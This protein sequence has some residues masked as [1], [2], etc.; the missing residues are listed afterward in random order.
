M[1]DSAKVRLV[2]CPKCENLLP[3]LADYSVYQCGGCGAVLRAKKKNCEVDAALSDK[4]DEERV[5]GLSTKSDISLDKEA[6]NLS[7]ASDTDVKPNGDSLRCGQRDS[8]KDD[9]MGR[10]KEERNSEIKST[11]GFQRSGWMSDWKFGES[12][13][14]DGLQINHKS[15]VEGVRL[16][17]SNHP[18]EGPSN[19][20]VD[21]PYSYG[22][23]SRNDNDPD[24][25]NR[26]MYLEQD[27]AELLRKLDELKDQLSRSCSVVEKPKEK[28]P[29]DGRT[30]HPDPYGGC[31]NWF[32]N[33]PSALNR[34]SMQFSG[35][36]KHVA[37]QPYSNCWPDPFPCTNRHEV[38][39]HG[40]YP[41]M[42]NP[43]H[44][45]VLG[46]PFGS[47]GLRR[48]S[49]HLPSQY[50]HPPLHPYFSG[51]YVDHNPESFE[52]YQTNSMFH[53]PSCSCL[54]CYDTLQ[55]VS[56]PAPAPAPSFCNKRFPN[57]PNH[58]VMYQHEKPGAFG[59]LGHNSTIPPPSSNSDPQHHTRWPSDLNSEMGGFV[60]CHPRRVVVASGARHCRP[61]AGGAPFLTCYNCFKVLQL[62]KKVPVTLKKQQKMRC[63]ACSAVINV[64]VID[65]KLVLS[66]HAQTKDIPIDYDGSSSELVKG[67]SSHFHGHMNRNKANFSSD[68]YDESDYNFQSIDVEPVSLSMGMG[69]NSNKAGEM[70]SFHS[71]SPSPSEDESG[72]EVLIASKDNST[73]Q[74]TR[75]ILSPPPPG[76]PLQEHFDHSSN[77]NVVN[78]F[79]KGNRSSRS[80]QEKVKPSKAT[81]RQNSLKE[82]SH[83]TEMDVSFNDYTNTGV[84]QDSGDAN[85]ED[86]RPRN[87]G[88]ESFFANIIKKSF[89]DFSRSNQTDE[90]SRSN[91]SVNGHLIPERVLRKAEK[92]AGPIQPGKY[93]YDSRAGFWGVM[94]GPCLGIIPPFIEEFNY[95]MPDNCAGG[96]TGVFVNGR[97]LHQ[98]DLDLLANRGLPT[99]RD[100]SYIIEISGSVLDEDNGEELDGLG[101]LAPT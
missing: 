99:A 69:S 24:R 74:P 9:T 98:K 79:A 6:V 10:D 83:A 17:T 49:H 3:E 11:S 55:R 54:H 1:A 25:V 38:A 20:N 66:V 82:A 84:S 37:G 47:Q 50:P 73:Q 39:M 35:H 71:S 100:R 2:R 4:S 80:D 28:V 16:S 64:A 92:R 67:C 96:N 23:L 19:Y 51:Q 63:G 65:K 27:R 62:P 88:S 57:V 101:K 15:N 85:R 59:Q 29:L 46:D 26:V 33:G 42:H 61:M 68:D 34:A 32:R 45:P 44:N 36:D 7:D 89:R 40:F 87:K 22:E 94:G 21:S 60:C 76:S 48:A 81:S 90:R 53:Q 12:D 58:P 41:S 13:E 78:R 91:V 14:M 8:E 31:D 52:P 93:W 30:V 5:G 77:N 70:G 43:N 97:E 18:D 95:P 86:D 75:V 56:A 72:P